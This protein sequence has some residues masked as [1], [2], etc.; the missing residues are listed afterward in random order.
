MLFSKNPK[1][2]LEKMLVFGAIGLYVA[3]H[4][5]LKKEG[6]LAGEPDLMLKIDKKKMFDMAQK[7][8]KLNPAIRQT[9]EGLYD[10]MLTEKDENESST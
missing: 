9:M 3:K 8:L 5:K 7:H 1:L 2:S 4:I 6:Q 10:T